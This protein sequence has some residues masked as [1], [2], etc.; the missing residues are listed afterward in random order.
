MQF[1]WKGQ[2]KPVTTLMIGTSPVFELALYTLCFAAGQERNR[3]TI[4]RYDLLIRWVGLAWSS[5]D[6]GALGS[7][8]SAWP[9]VQQLC[10]WAPLHEARCST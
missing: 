10:R 6:R 1:T 3:V 8:C 4:D 5:E 7:L 2:A 9:N